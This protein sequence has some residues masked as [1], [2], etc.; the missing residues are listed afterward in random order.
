MRHF[1]GLCL[2]SLLLSGCSYDETLRREISESLERVADAIADGIRGPGDSDPPAGPTAAEIETDLQ[3]VIESADTEI[4]SF[5]GAI[6]ACQALSCRQGGNI[7]VTGT[8]TGTVVDTSGF[9]FTQTRRGVSLAERDSRSQ[10]GSTSYR[11]LA[12]WTEHHFF[13]IEAGETSIHGESLVT[14]EVLSIGDSTGTNPAVPDT[15]SATWSGTMAGFVEPSASDG[16]GSFVDGDAT[17]TV[18]DVAANISPAVDVRFS[19]I[20][21]DDTGASLADMTW[22]AVTMTDGAFGSPKVIAPVVAS[23]TDITGKAIQTG[24]YGR[25]HGPDH[26]EVGGAFRRD[27]ITGVF[28]AMLDE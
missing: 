2:A 11:H 26:E 3:S 5:G 23:D 21:K 28:G 4:S 14:Y 12:G 15:G 19:N 18:P 10:D 13:L 17:I 20:V 25:F 8:P 27:G 24:I 16:D 1:I 6:A 7:Y 9:E 22:N